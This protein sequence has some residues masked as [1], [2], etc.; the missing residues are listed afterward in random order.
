MSRALWALFYTAGF[1]GLTMA[2]WKG[3]LVLADSLE[4]V[5]RKK[6]QP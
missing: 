4:R 3:M 1:V 6:D 2:V 5:T